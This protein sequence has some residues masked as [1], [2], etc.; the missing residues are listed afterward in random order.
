MILSVV[1]R[2]ASASAALGCVWGRALA[3]L[4]ESAGIA[5]SSV[6]VNLLCDFT[7]ELLGGLC[8]QLCGSQLS[9]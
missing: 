4:V 7:V 2:S 8:Q 1:G 9:L 3:E 5:I 6:M